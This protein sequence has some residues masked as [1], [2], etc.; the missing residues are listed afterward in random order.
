LDKKENKEA[1]AYSFHA[2]NHNDRVITLSTVS[3]A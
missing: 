3:L 1:F 2:Y